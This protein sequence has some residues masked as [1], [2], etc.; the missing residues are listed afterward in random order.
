[1]QILTIGGWPINIQIKTKLKLCKGKVDS[2]TE[3]LTINGL[4]FYDSI[5]AFKNCNILILS[6]Y[7]YYCDF[8]IVFNHFI[9]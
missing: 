6:G 5:F 1:M 8:K 9:Q 7:R 4:N 2:N 3:T